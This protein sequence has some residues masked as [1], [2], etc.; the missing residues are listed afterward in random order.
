MTCDKHRRGFGPLPRPGAWGGPGRVRSAAEIEAEEAERLAIAHEASQRAI[1]AMVRGGA[2][3]GDGPTRI[4]GW[5][6]R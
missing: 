3:P 2:F 4:S 5:G 1:E 6:D